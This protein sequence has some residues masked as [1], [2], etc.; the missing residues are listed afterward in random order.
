MSQNKKLWKDFTWPEKR[1]KFL[2]FALIFL[3]FY[4]LVFSARE[5]KPKELKTFDIT[6]N[7]EPEFKISKG[8]N[9]RYWLEIYCNNEI[10]ELNGIDYKYLN[11]KFFKKIIHKD[12]AISISV[13]NNKIYKMKYKNH[14]LLNY[15]LAE[16]HKTKNLV[17][18][19][20]I[21]LSGFLLNVFPLFFRKAPTYTNYYSEIVEFDFIKFFAIFWIISIIVAVI[22]LGDFKY[23]SS[24]EFIKAN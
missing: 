9:S 6:L 19:Q 22:Y 14:N 23:I 15:D 16:I 4:I 17:F 1:K 7:K 24:A 20:I 11:D 13:F 8:K 18:F 2:L 12:S 5:P 10:Y 21:I 3:L